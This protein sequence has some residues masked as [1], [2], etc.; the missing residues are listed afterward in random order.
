M[1]ATDAA[2]RL[3]RRY[4]G[5]VAALAARMAANANTLQH[6]VN[7]N[8]KGHRLSLAEAE[9]MTAFSQ[10]P[11]IAE[12]LALACGHVCIPVSSGNAGE[13]AENI[14][15]VGQEFGDVMKATLMAIEDGRVTAR[16]LAEYDRQFH[17]FLGAAVSLRT[18]LEEKIPKAPELKLAER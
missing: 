10:D 15:A 17:Q 9:E 8:A 4:P 3:A 18:K 2:Y 14:A 7:P 1:S 6:K 13:L 11:E 12:A 16:E 5:G